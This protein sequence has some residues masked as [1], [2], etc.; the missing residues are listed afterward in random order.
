MLFKPTKF[1]I[2]ILIIVS[3][4]KR[5]GLTWGNLELM[6]KNLFHPCM[7]VQIERL[8][9]C[10]G[11]WWYILWQKCHRT[12]SNIIFDPWDGIWKGGWSVSHAHFKFVGVRFFSFL[13][14]R[15]SNNLHAYYWACEKFVCEVKPRCERMFEI[16]V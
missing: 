7:M 1:S 5:Y 3:K 16:R 13:K 15:M 10:C 12:F 4:A 8:Q 14:G 6:D 11:E 9:L 2:I